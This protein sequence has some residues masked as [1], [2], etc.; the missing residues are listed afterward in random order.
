MKIK[1]VCRFLAVLAICPHTVLAQPTPPGGGGGGGGTNTYNFTNFVTMPYLPGVKLTINAANA[2]NLSFGFL[3]ADPAAKYDIYSESNLTAPSWSD[4]LQG[5]NGQTNFTLTVSPS[6]N[7]FF[8]TARTDTPITNTASMTVSF[9]NEYVNTNFVVAD[10]S[11]GPAAA[12]AYLVNDTNTADARWFPFSAV[13]YVLLGTTDGTYQVEFGFVGSDGQTN[14]TSATVT[15]DTTP[16]TLVVTNP[17]SSLVSQPMIQLQGYSIEPLS[18][19]TFDVSNALGVVTNEQGVVTSQN[20]DTNAWKFTTSY[21]QC[22]DLPLIQGTNLITIHG[23]DLAGNTTTTNCIFKLDYSSATNAPAIQIS[24]PQNGAQ[25]GGTNFTLHGQM[26]N[27]TATITAQIVGT[28]G[29]TNVVNGLVERDGNVWIENVPLNSGTNAVTVTATDAAGNVTATNLLLIQSSVTL[30]ITPVANSQLNLLTTTVTGNVSDP[31]YS[32]WVNGVEAT[33]DGYG[34]W[35]AANVPINDGGTACF[36]V[37]AYPESGTPSVNLSLNEDKPAAL[38]VLRYINYWQNIFVPSGAPALVLHPNSVVSSS[39]TNQSYWLEWDDAENSSAFLDTTNTLTEQICQLVFMWPP[40]IDILNVQTPT[41]TGTVTDSCNANDTN[42]APPEIP[43]EHCFIQSQSSTTGGT[44]LYTR[45]AQTILQLRTGG[46]AVAGQRTLFQISASA[47][48]STGAGIPPQAIAINDLGNLDTNGNLSTTLPEGASMNMTPLPTSSQ[49]LKYYTFNI[50]AT[51]HIPGDCQVSIQTIQNAEEPGYVPTTDDCGDNSATWY[52]QPG[53]FMISRTGDLLRPLTVE[54]AVGGT[55]VPA[56]EYDLVSQWAD[57]ASGPLPSAT[58]RGGSPL[59]GALYVLMAPGQSNAVVEVAPLF[60]PFD[61]GSLTV[62]VSLLG[63]GPNGVNSTPYYTI[64]TS[65][66]NTT[67]YVSD[68]DVDVWYPTFDLPSTPLTNGMVLNGAGGLFRE[69][70]NPT[71]QRGS[72]V[73]MGPVNE[74][75]FFVTEGKLGVDFTFDDSGGCTIAAAGSC[76]FRNNADPYN[77]NP[78]ITLNAYRISTTFCIG[79]HVADSPPDYL[80]Y[81]NT[82]PFSITVL[83]HDG[84]TKP[85]WFFWDAN[86]FAPNQMQLWEQ[87]SPWCQ[88]P[89]GGLPL[90]SQLTGLYGG[91]YATFWM[92]N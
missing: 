80:T 63:D 84:T 20:F 88:F 39:P 55:A 11:G 81:M 4:I 57:G 86:P 29:V 22:F 48:D 73:G 10:V 26:N 79:W 12:M 77:P 37:T 14:W 44:Y 43:L 32:V 18:S 71:T 42:T 23:T 56:Q 36:N 45:N 58:G 66:S 64:N 21:F 82:P 6:G 25:I 3:E 30:S 72:D 35:N 69:D 65:S 92:Q 67:V 33:V 75:F 83:A 68:S 31:S 5:S 1:N 15:V 17:D 9:P 24:W 60:Y 27:P 28:N 91:G 16:P 49:G 85:C 34:N 2:T 50:S 53:Y 13:P 40:D 62:D 47:S 61:Y 74:D 76:Q 7:G 46:K 8:R 52:G 78:V 89:Q 70:Y 51:N 90:L 59:G 41:Q 54:F 19:L 38:F 87:E